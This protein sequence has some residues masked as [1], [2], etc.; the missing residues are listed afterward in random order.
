MFQSL[1]LKIAKN[2]LIKFHINLCIRKQLDF[3]IKLFQLDYHFIKYKIS[4]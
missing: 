1:L 3:N 2:F 4:F